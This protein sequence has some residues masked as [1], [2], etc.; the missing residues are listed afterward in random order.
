VVLAGGDTV[1]LKRGDIRFDERACEFVTDQGN[2]YSIPAMKYEAVRVKNAAGYYNAKDMELVDLFI[3]CEGT[4]G[5]FT[6]I[7][8]KLMPKSALVAG[9]SFMESR[10][11]AFAF[12]DFLR[13]DTC[14]MA[15]EYF[16]TSALHYIRTHKDEISL[17]LPD[18][19]QQAR[20]AVYW[21]FR[22]EK[23]GEFEERMEPWEH[24][25]NTFGSSF[26]LTWSGFDEQEM[27]RL[28]TFRHAVPELVNLRIAQLQRSIPSIRKV[29]TDAAV[30]E[31]HLESFFKKSLQ[32]IEM[33][34][35]E[36]I[37][38][39]HLGDCHL[40]FN[41]IPS[42][43]RQMKDALGIY[44]R[45]MQE[46]VRV[47][48]TVSAEHGIGKLKREYLGLMYGEEAIE[49]MKRVKRALDPGWLLNSGNLF[50]GRGCLAG[51]Q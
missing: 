8:I 5:I 10:E 48:G 21:E 40:H 17:K 47:G 14:V 19:P 13:K 36:T 33:K 27:L 7:G 43:E 25:L 37:V 30:P 15:I 23:E 41:M 9:L 31:K 11:G 1:G 44:K 32:L 20:A 29:G 45:I 39:G 38:F 34:G 4:L 24:T 50:E 18:L 28:K 42:S 22:E 26:D 51:Q 3:G 6:E 12:A 46:A 16:D 35:I 2:R 49:E